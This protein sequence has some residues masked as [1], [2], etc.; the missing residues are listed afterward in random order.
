MNAR[1]HSPWPQHTR[2]RVIPQPGQKIPVTAF[3]GHNVGRPSN[4]RLSLLGLGRATAAS[5]TQGAGLPKKRLTVP[6][7]L[8]G[9]GGVDLIE[10]TLLKEGYHDSQ[11]HHRTASQNV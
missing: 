4:E 1:N 6:G 11:P 10:L 5:R 3:S 9:G 8:G 7:A 2:E